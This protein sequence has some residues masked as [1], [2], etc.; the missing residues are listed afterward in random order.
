MAK[1]QQK[2]NIYQ[3]VTD[4][5]LAELALQNWRPAPC[6]GASPGVA[7]AVSRYRCAPL[8][9]VIAA[10]ERVALNRFSCGYG[11]R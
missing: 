6:R 5:I 8:A 9:R 1:S 7:V 3:H 2:F 11:T 4:T 10:L